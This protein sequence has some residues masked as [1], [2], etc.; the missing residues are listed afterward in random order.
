MGIKKILKNLQEQLSKGE[1]KGH[2]SL[3]RID[4]LLL[5]LA[6]KERKLKQKLSKEKD[7]GKRKHLKLELQIARLELKKSKKRRAEL[8]SKGK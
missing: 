8:S 3:D 4:G 7:S 6:K 1:K 5:D 2:A